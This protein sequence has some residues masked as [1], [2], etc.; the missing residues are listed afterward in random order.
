MKNVCLFQRCRVLAAGLSVLVLAG[1]GRSEPPT[2]QAS[3]TQ[4]G[5]TE[6]QKVGP[7]PATEK[8]VEPLL[9]LS[10][11]EIRAA[12]IKVAGLREE[13][14]AEQLTV[15]AT[16]RPN[17]DRIVHVAPRVAGRIVKVQANLG[18]AVLTGQTLAVL[19]SLE[20]GEAHSAYL[21][22]RTAQA[23]AKADFERAEK[24]HGEQII[25]QK[26]HLRAH[27]EYEK[28]KAAFAAAA[29][30]LRMLG[31]SQVPA[32][33]GKAVSTFPLISPFTGTVIEKH[34]ILGELAQPDKQLF[35]VADLSRLWIEAN[36]FEKDLS[37][38]QVGAPAVITVAAYPDEAFQGQLT[39]IAAVVDK[40]TRTVQAR[41]EVSN[42]DGRLKPEMFATAAIHT[43]SGSN[44]K[45]I[46]LPEEG[47]ILMQGQPTVFV[48]AGGGFEPR[49]VELGVRLRD[50][51]EVTKGLAVGERVVTA[52]SYALKARL[53]KAQLGE[54]H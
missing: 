39:Y 20:V 40:E 21:Q 45:A 35:V 10:A 41:V 51:V 48:E 7:S 47:V 18:D 43:R 49:P 12:G 28:S 29:D 1:C 23:V 36:L 54:S 37:K 33:N 30:R 44:R 34:A 3:A 42:L 15:T 26:D 50:R 32:I 27:A 22:A 2:P 11:E 19:D 4:Q 25:A 6:T 16:I 53:L 8:A 46:L 9:K 31:V 52:G 5:A 24:L 13:E 14:V 38:I 17:Q